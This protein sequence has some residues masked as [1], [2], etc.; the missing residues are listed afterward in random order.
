[1]IL[2]EAENPTVKRSKVS[3]IRLMC[4]FCIYRKKINRHNYRC[5]CQNPFQI[6]L[7]LS[8]WEQ[9]EMKDKPWI[10]IY[11][12]RH[13]IYQKTEALTTHVLVISCI[14]SILEL[15]SYSILSTSGYGEV[16]T[17]SLCCAQRLWCSLD[18]MAKWTGEKGENDPLWWMPWGRSPACSVFAHGWWCCP[19]SFIV[20]ASRWWPS[21][22]GRV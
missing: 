8:R 22:T 5:I 17:L 19:L 4:C 11:Q 14:N 18:R 15:D 21:S 7:T 20:L 3:L 16:A 6:N 2:M 12:K 1:M 10:S 9:Q 13:P